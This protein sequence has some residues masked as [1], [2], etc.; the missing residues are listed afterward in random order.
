[1]AFD[2]AFAYFGANR[3]SQAIPV[4]SPS[5][6]P[7]PP[8]PQG[9]PATIACINPSAPFGSTHVQENAVYEVVA[10]PGSS[11]S[12][13][14]TTWNYAVDNAPFAPPAAAVGHVH[15]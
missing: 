4:L 5:G 12:Y 1:M 8:V 13:Q 2:A 7:V 11:P 14:I 3:I 9:P 6:T 10:L 15:Q